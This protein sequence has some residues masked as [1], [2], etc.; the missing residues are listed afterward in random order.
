MHGTNY[1]L[2]FDGLMTRGRGWDGGEEG[3]KAK[4]AA[5]EVI[6][7]LSGVF[8]GR[9]SEIDADQGSHQRPGASRDRPIPTVW[10]YHSFISCTLCAVE[11]GPITTTT[12]TTCACVPCMPDDRNTLATRSTDGCCGALSVLPF[13]M[14]PNLQLNVRP[15]RDDQ[16]TSVPA[17]TASLTQGKAE[18]VEAKDWE[19]RLPF[20]FFIFFVLLVLAIFA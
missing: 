10:S 5:A 1:S 14:L 12:L 15:V 13:Q 17:Q 16:P 20:L 18:R 7:G 3:R 11:R 19:W 2:T 4:V 9:F 6:L 8:I